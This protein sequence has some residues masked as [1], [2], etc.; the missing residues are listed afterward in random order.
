MNSSTKQSGHNPSAMMS[1]IGSRIL[2][3][4]ALRGF[5]LFGILIVNIAYFAS[6]YAFHLVE[7]PAYD[8]WLD[9]SAHWLVKFLFEMKFYLLF[10]FLFGYSF[11]LQVDS[12]IRK[13]VTFFPRFLRRLAGLF[14]L[15]TLHAVLLFHG[16]IL[17][18]YAILGS[19]LLAAQRIQPRT[20]LITAGILIG[21]I[22]FMMALAA[23]AGV[24]LVADS[25]AAIAD[26]QQSTAALQ[27]GLDS[28]ISEHLRSMPDMLSALAVQ[29][30]LALS[31]FLVG[32]AAG[33]GRVLANLNKHSSMLRRLQLVGYPI[34][35][36][37][38]LV[39]AVC[40]G[41]SDP[42]G[43][44]VSILTAPFLVAAYVATMLR[45]FSSDW[46]RRVAKVLAPAGRMALS[47]YLGQ[48]LFCALIFTGYGLGLIG[49][50]PPLIVLFIATAIFSAQLLLSALWLKSHHYGPVEWIL[51][52]VTNAEWPD[53][54]RR[55]GK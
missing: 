7:D 5:A 52:A 19:V 20:A 42:L 54:R 51:R 13:G 34:G 28:V 15:G 26:G 14:V 43:L 38:A 39:F 32:L 3:V 41:T 25:A 53:W 48:S 23:A 30:P 44:T 27:G 31:A 11:T 12:A 50:V 4:D 47:N 40:G 16:D 10:S 9:K 18:T 8:S 1:S 17:T 21:I 45:I 33:K 55:G 24:T 6:G 29:G 46:G 22:T 2:D 49:R 35:L 37:G 36:A